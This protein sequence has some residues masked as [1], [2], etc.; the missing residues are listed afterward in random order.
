M[1][2]PPGASYP[3]DQM[4]SNSNH[5]RSSYG[6]ADDKTTRRRSHR[7]RGCR[8]GSNRRKNDNGE[9]KNR[10]TYNKPM[11]KGMTKKQASFKT[12][13][14]SYNKFTHEKKQSLSVSKE[15]S[16]GN[17]LSGPGRYANNSSCSN[18]ELDS[19]EFNSLSEFNS[20]SDLSSTGTDMQPSFSESS[21]EEG[22]PNPKAL[23][24]HPQNQNRY[25]LPPLPSTAFHNLEPVPPRGPNPYALQP[26]TQHNIYPAQ[27]Q[28]SFCMPYPQLSQKV[29][30]FFQ[31]SNE[32]PTPGL[33]VFQACPGP[34][35]KAQRLAKQR[36]SVGGSLFCTSPR[37]FL[38]GKQTTTTSR[39]E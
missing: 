33:A 18:S 29:D 31:G 22:I 14:P 11:K 5:S 23:S 27:Q 28:Q 1:N 24:F 34:D 26:T 30:P 16:S 3:S 19:S 20:S 21:S 15:M 38:M 9:N 25:I 35:Y 6:G 2:K 4:L 7:P 8:G 36:Q 12:S 17:M 39:S 37:S 10:N 32:N 13:R